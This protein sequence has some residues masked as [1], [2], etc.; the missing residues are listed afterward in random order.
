MKKTG[1]KPIPLSTNPD[2]RQF[3]DEDDYNYD[4]WGYENGGRWNEDGN[5]WPSLN[6]REDDCPKLRRHT[7]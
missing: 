4:G 2:A 7:N 3:Q 6:L 5:L 1:W